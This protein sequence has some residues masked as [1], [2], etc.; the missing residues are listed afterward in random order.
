MLTQTEPPR[1]PRA[2]NSLDWASLSLI[3]LSLLFAPLTAGY[4]STPTRNSSFPLTLTEILGVSLPSLLAAAGAMLTFYRES[5][6]PVAIGSVPGVRASWIGLG[7]WA[8]LTALG[9]PVHFLSVNAL[10]ALFSALLLGAMVSRLGRDRNA[11]AALVITICIAGT[12]ASFATV[13]EYLEQYSKGV[14]NY[15]AFGGFVNPDFLAGYLLVTLLVTLA[16]FSSAR[17]KGTQIGLGA[18]VF[19]QAAATM[20]TGS[21]AGVGVLLIA[22]L[23]WIGIVAYTGELKTRLKPVLA[24]LA[25][26]VFGAILASAPTL[27]RVT[28][29]GT[30]VPG[31]TS[32]IAETAA[33][34]SHSAEFRKYTWIGTAKMAQKNPILGTGIGS[35]ETSYSRYSITAFTAHAHNAY[36]QWAGE[37]G[38]V[39]GLILMTGFASIGAFALRIL[40][41]GARR[42]KNLANTGFP[43]HE[44]ESELEKDTPFPIFASPLI[45]LSGLIAA[46]L[47]SLM[48]SFIDSDWYLVATLFTLAAVLGLMLA[49]S[50]DFAPLSTERPAPLP[51]ALCLGGVVLCL[52]V[53]GRGSTQILARS[54]F[55]SAAL[56]I[57]ERKSQD[58]LDAYGS[59]ATFDPLD[60]EPHLQSAL[61]LDSLGTPEGTAKA[62][63][64]LLAAEKLAPSGRTF[65]RL[66]QHYGRPDGDTEKQIAAY[67]EALKREPNNVQTLRALGDT[68]R[69][70]N[71][72][73]EAKNTYTALTELERSP[74]GTVRAMPEVVEMEFAYAHVALAEI[75]ST[76]KNK[77]VA[78]TEYEAAAKLFREYWGKRNNGM[79]GATLQ[80]MQQKQ[81]KY[82]QAYLDL[83]AHWLSDL[84]SDAPNRKIIEAEMTTIGTG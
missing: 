53:I 30:G 79:Y 31:G 70:A 46:L 63:I 14:P 55:S 2:L 29:R 42:R 71:K 17:D 77:A 74:Y 84:P 72:L 1:N 19:L 61:I 13:W 78:L 51:S 28:G 52:I 68:Q 22:L 37:T 66:A 82:R 44:T 67:E 47:A 34:Q 16:A 39:G 25:I 21:R 49:V 60:P 38:F 33:A 6:R 23:L 83:L 3:A 62:E 32:G 64:E 26:F 27:S 56:S 40:W 18:A 45:L 15:R 48:H 9:N 10:V 5:K 20:L 81:E 50:R 65:Y 43:D 80:A 58:A 75:A 11:I 8:S 36:L 54:Q 35:F 7:V 76:A 4:F 24:G 59:A 41:I 73:T 57:A 69:K 12:F